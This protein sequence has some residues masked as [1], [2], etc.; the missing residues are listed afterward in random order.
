MIEFSLHIE[1]PRNLVTRL[2]F[3]AVAQLLLTCCLLFLPLLRGFWV[4]SVLCNIQYVV[5]FIVCNHLG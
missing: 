2:L 5:S 4:W 1:P 3:K